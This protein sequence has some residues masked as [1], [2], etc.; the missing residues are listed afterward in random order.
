M[1]RAKECGYFV[2]GYFIL[3]RSPEINIKRIYGR[4]QKGLHYV[5]EDK[6]RSRYEK[7]LLNIPQFV[8]ICD[9]C[10]IYDNSTEP[11]RIFRKHKEQETIYTSRNWTEQKL[12][13]LVYGE[14]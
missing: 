4:V 5:P 13:R 2:R 3:T 8:E 10:H 6:V 12:L 14:E 9:I 7:A 11:T 1:K